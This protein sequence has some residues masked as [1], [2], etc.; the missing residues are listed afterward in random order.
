MA[1]KPTNDTEHKKKAVKKYPTHKD[2]R[3]HKGSGQYPNYWSHKTRSGHCII[4]DDSKDHES[5]SIQHRG[6]SCIQFMPDGA[7]QIT[8]HNGKYDVVFGE[9]R[10]T[11]TG[12]HDITVKGDAT[13]LV[14]GDLHHTIHGNYNHTVT[15]DYN[16]TA[17]NMNSTIRQNFDTN[18]GG[19]ETRKIAAEASYHVHGARADVTDGSHTVASNK[20]L[21]LGGKT[22]WHGYTP[23]SATLHADQN[24]H[25]AAQQKLHATGEGGMLLASS[26]FHQKV[27]GIIKVQGSRIDFQNG[28]DKAEKGQ[29]KSSGSSAKPTMEAKADSV[30]KLA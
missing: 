14:Y 23:A 17:K 26:T 25:L 28:A 6:G 13:M 21:A 11:V 30:S 4:M 29:A 2:A 8:A 15:G 3:Q 12:A 9:Q 7:I 18:I 20:E 5:I 22:G 16:L 24:V 1:N 19:S 10:M 27:D